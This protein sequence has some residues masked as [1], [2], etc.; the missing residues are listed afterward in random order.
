[1]RAKSSKP[2]IC[3]RKVICSLFFCFQGVLT[4]LFKIIW[5]VRNSSFIRP[6]YACFVIVIIIISVSFS[7]KG[8]FCPSVYYPFFSFW[9]LRSILSFFIRSPVFGLQRA[10]SK[11]FSEMGSQDLLTKEN[12]FPDVA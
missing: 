5:R 6:P 11:W 1:M 10:I 3:T 12:D 2:R 4:S 7:L 8:R 9:T